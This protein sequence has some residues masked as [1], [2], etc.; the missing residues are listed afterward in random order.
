LKNDVD[1]KYKNK[2][3]YEDKINLLMND[4]KLIIDNEQ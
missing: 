3:S 2:I 1:E 4:H